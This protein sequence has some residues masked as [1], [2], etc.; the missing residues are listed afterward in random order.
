MQA[1][2]KMLDLLA[3]LI[4]GNN[5]LNQGKA[6][7]GED[8]GGLM[9]FDVLNAI[10][11]LNQ[12]G[13]KNPMNSGFLNPDEMDL[14]A[15]MM[16]DG[17]KSKAAPVI[18]PLSEGENRFVSLNPVESGLINPKD[19]D[20]F[21]TDSAVKAEQS[22]DSKSL[23]LENI[24][25][26][27]R[28]SS[29]Y[30]IPADSDIQQIFSM[31]KAKDSQRFLPVMEIASLEEL[32]NFKPGE[33]LTLSMPLNETG[34]A[35]EISLI[36]TGKTESMGG[37]EFTKLEVEIL[38]GDKLSK[39][40]AVMIGDKD[41]GSGQKTLGDLLGRL[42]Q[43][44][45]REA[46]LVVFVPEDAK[47][48]PLRNHLN[49]QK[50]PSLKTDNAAQ[51]VRTQ[52]V[53]GRFVGDDALAQLR[54]LEM[55]ESNPDKNN[56][57]FK[58]EAVSQD[59]RRLNLAIGN[60]GNSKFNQ[61]MSNQNLN[62]GSAMKSAFDFANPQGLSGESFSDKMGEMQSSAS[63]DN[64][65]GRVAEGMKA[66]MPEMRD[67]SQFR[68]VEFKLEPPKGGTRIPEGGYF[69]IKLEPESLGKID[70]ELRVE[71]D[72]LV[73][74]MKVDTPLA[75]Q[76]VEANLPQLRESLHQNGIKAENIVVDLNS[77]ANNSDHNP[78]NS[79]AA[80]NQM[81]RNLRNRNL[82]LEPDDVQNLTEIPAANWN[83]NLRGN[84]SLLA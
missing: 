84:L 28:G 2:M 80:Q 47:M 35:E 8:N 1:N 30:F 51:A 36:K 64:S 60:E 71:H 27:P 19:I 29:D 76:V 54:Q 66:D 49:L 62:N 79:K 82:G 43:T 59:D 73:A 67:L 53:S 38:S 4:P 31:D 74:R 57:I 15:S 20:G 6:A 68:N 55:R 7:A 5:H 58:E 10:T 63:T 32:Q 39:L 26:T 72:K 18:I 41:S 45:G 21:L 37:R 16:A 61:N 17:G 78:E 12:K 56:T 22:A 65:A 23:I 24:P 9:F 70:V 14:I 42:E 13:G 81:F 34:Q 69:R 11:E 77:N 52:E 46:K 44:N 33:R 40:D 48:E 25:A 83:L 75:R 3:A 50:E